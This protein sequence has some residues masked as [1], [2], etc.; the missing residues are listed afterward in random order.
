MH[1]VRFVAFPFF[2]LLTL[3]TLLGSYFTFKI[4]YL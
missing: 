4:N 1:K 2:N 3:L